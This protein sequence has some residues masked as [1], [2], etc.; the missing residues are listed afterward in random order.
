VTDRAPAEAAAE[1]QAAPEAAD[2]PLWWWARG[3]NLRER[4]D[5]PWP[6]AARRVA[7]GVGRLGLWSV[8]DRAGFAARLAALSLSDDLASALGEEL[9]TRLGSR[10]AKPA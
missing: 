4:L 7:T 5:A 3:L 9:P 2:L 8:G 1:A 10:T 6:P